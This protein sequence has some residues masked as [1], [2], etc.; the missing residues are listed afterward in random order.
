MAAGPGLEGGELLGFRCRDCGECCRLHIP[1]NDSDL[2]RLSAGT[3]MDARDIVQFVGRAAI[4]DP[5]DY[6]GW[7]RMGPGPGAAGGEMMMCLREAHGRCLF[8]RESRCAVYDHRPSVCRLHPL[9][10]TLSESGRRIEKIE[11]YDPCS[12]AGALDGHV[13]ENDLLRLKRRSEREDAAYEESI[14]IWNAGGGGSAGEFFECLGLTGT[15]RADAAG[16]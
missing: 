7:I 12:C 8:R 2:R 4:V 6:D 9:D 14:R 10:V 3:G 11:A 5:D 15:L 13:D 16:D 1:V